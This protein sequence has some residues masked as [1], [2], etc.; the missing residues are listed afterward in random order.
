MDGW[1]SHASHLYD[2]H[3]APLRINIYIYKGRAEEKKNIIRFPF[4]S[5]SSNMPEKDINILWQA[6]CCVC[7]HTFQLKREKRVL[8]HALLACCTAAVLLLTFKAPFFTL[9]LLYERRNWTKNVFGGENCMQHLLLLLVFLLTFYT[10]CD[11]LSISQLSLA[12]HWPWWIGGGSPEIV[13]LLSY[14]YITSRDFFFFFA[15]I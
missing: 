15:V 10:K 2:D 1:S 7:I 5:P 11:G 8:L 4:F 9:L 6:L 14:I 12:A 13:I 3:P